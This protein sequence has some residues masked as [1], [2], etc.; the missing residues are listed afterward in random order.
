MPRR[1]AFV[2]PEGDYIS[3]HSRRLIKALSA[4]PVD[5]FGIDSYSCVSVS[6]V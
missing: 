3:W 1:R 4:S 5:N 2:S 6:H